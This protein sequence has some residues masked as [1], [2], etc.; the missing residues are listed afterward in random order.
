MAA[1]APPVDRTA[2]VTWWD[3]GAIWVMWI[4]AAAGAQ[5]TV[6]RTF[7]SMLRDLQVA[8]AL[9]GSAAALIV[10]TVA[11]LALHRG[12][13]GPMFR[14]LWGAAP[15]SRHVLQG[16]QVGGVSFVFCQVALG[17]AA[18]ALMGAVGLEVAPQ[19]LQV[20]FGS[21]VPTLIAATTTIVLAPV[22]EELLY[23]GVL[24]Q[25]LADRM[26]PWSAVTISSLLFGLAHGQVLSMVVTGAFGALLAIARLRSGTLAVPIVAHMV[27]N[28]VAFTLV[29]SR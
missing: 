6:V 9:A 15:T 24:L 25:G 12:Q 10:V 19:P 28:A 16:L 18:A 11:W 8:V 5:V 26:P 29:M 14:R 1:S 22:G 4:V 21:A 7:P 17:T 3:A 20:A 27:F 13:T 2:A 23:R